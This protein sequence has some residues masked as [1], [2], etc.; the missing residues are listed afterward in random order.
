V[1]TWI[2]N[3]V[4][5]VAKTVIF[6]TFGLSAAIIIGSSPAHAGGETSGCGPNNCTPPPLPTPN[7]GNNGGGGNNQPNTTNQSSSNNN[8][9]QGSFT[10]VG[11]SA[12]NLGLNGVNSQPINAYAVSGVCQGTR[13]SDG[14]Y[15]NASAIGSNFSPAYA[16]TLGYQLT[17]VRGSAEFDKMCNRALDLRVDELRLDACDR[18]FKSEATYKRRFN[19]AAS[20]FDAE[21]KATCMAFGDAPTEVRVIE[22]IVEVPAKPQELPPVNQEPPV[23]NPQ[24]VPNTGT[25][26][27]H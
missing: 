5:Y 3:A 20:K 14:Y 15:A 13:G 27:Y 4:A 2:T 7:G 21:T 8:Q 10:N 12:L 9:N 25:T 1:N 19:W 11:G 16:L 17:N 23:R 26:G 24:R 18:V 22:K 6:G